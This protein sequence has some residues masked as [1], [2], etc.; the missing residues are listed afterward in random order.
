[1]SICSPNLNA[2][3][4]RFIQTLQKECLDHFVVFGCR[5]ID[6]LL[7]EFLLHYHPERPNRDLATNCCRSVIAIA[8]TAA[9]ETLD[10]ASGSANWSST[11]TAR[12]RVW[13]RA[14]SSQLRSLR[15]S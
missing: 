11:I 7:K 12:R 1:L 8:Q 6:H 15:Q 14:A 10:A 13:R 2:Y 4:E 3:V 9:S 5:H